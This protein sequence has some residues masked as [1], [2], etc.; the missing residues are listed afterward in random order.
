MYNC[1]LQPRELRKKPDRVRPATPPAPPAHQ[2][3]TVVDL[4]SEQ[5][6]V[7]CAALREVDVTVS[8]HGVVT[9]VPVR[10]PACPTHHLDL[11]TPQQ[12]GSD[13]AMGVAMS[14]ITRRV[15]ATA[16]CRVCRAR[17]YVAFFA[18]CTRHFGLGVVLSYAVAS[19][20]F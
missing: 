9:T 8:Y 14:D 11:S 3:D 10:V 18:V 20:A 12:H 2:P 7:A 5:G 17:L 19:T 4:E 16:P 15:G 6:H 1:W 13:H